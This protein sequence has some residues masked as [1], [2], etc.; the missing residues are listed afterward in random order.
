MVI[1]FGKLA[2]FL[3]YQSDVKRNYLILSKLKATRKLILIKPNSN[4]VS[5]YKFI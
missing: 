2:D 5:C 4:S 1:S 3:F